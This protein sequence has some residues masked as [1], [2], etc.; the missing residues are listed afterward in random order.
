MKKTDGFT[1]E[2]YCGEERRGTYRF[3][4]EHAPDGTVRFQEIGR[5]DWVGEAARKPVN[6]ALLRAAE[7]VLS[8]TCIEQGEARQH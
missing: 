4:R 1:A 2:V 8:G 3:Q 6:Q 7:R 5:K